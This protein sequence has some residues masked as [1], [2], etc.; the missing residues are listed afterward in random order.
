M[1]GEFLKEAG[2]DA[3]WARVDKLTHSLPSHSKDGGRTRVQRIPD[4][5]S[6][7]QQGH[8]S[9]MDAMITLPTAKARKPLA[10]AKDGEKKK[11]REVRAVQIEVR[12]RKPGRSEIEQGG[13]SDSI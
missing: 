13:H 12:E 6:T 4:I 7:D 10:A 5:I 11:E 1:Y 9:L 8:V 3:C 2:N